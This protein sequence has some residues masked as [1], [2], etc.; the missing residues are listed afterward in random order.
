VLPAFLIFC[1]APLKK[2][3]KVPLEPAIVLFIAWEKVA[4]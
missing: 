4:Y 1:D 3:E 2:I